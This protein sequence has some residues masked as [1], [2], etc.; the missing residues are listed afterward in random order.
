VIATASPQRKDQVLTLLQLAAHTSYAENPA[1][2]V[3]MEG[4]P[5]MSTITVE[6]PESV[7]SALAPLDGMLALD[8]VAAK[9]M[10]AEA[11]HMVGREIADIADEM[12]DLYNQFSKS[13]PADLR[14]LS[15]R[16]EAGRRRVDAIAAAYESY[17]GL[18][19]E[20][21]RPG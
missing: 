5:G 18:P 17:S 19:D 10:L 2:D 9:D 12:E 20:P 15:E 14:A 7:A 21:R 1:E 3:A 13:A 6:V 4:T 16:L 11:V 8:D